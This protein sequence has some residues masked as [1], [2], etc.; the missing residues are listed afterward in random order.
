MLAV[1]LIQKKMLAEALVEGEK[2]AI[3]SGRSPVSLA[4]VGSCHA[5]LGKQSEAKKMIEE[6][7]QMSKEKHAYLLGWIYTFLGDKARPNLA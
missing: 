3:Y 6:L 4:C 7:Q 5:A 1:A 2:A